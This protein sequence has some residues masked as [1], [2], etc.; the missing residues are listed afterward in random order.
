MKAI[1]GMNLTEQDEVMKW[2]SWAY[3]VM[4]DKPTDKALLG[5]V[6]QSAPESVKARRLQ[7][8]QNAKAWMDSQRSKK[9]SD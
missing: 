9:I 6:A 7:G 8:E 3:G 5:V 1:V 4:R 2:A